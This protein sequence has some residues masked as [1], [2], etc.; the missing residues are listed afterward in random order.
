M[1]DLSDWMMS[2]Q[3]QLNQD[4][5]EFLWLGTVGQ[6]AKLRDSRPELVLSDCT[7]DQMKPAVLELLLTRS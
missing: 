1:I 7:C 5:T 2:H 3:L 6:L 4:K